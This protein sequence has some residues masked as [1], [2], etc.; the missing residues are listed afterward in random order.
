MKITVWGAR[1]SH[2]HPMT[3]ARFQDRVRSIVQRIGPEDI[4]S[5]EN[6]ERFLSSLPD[7]M[8]HIPGGNTPCV[9]IEL[10]DGSCIVL[11][12]GSGMIP[13]SQSLFSRPVTPELFHIFFSHFH[14]D[15]IQGL[16]F[17]TQ[18]YF[19]N[20]HLHFYSPERDVEFTLKEHMHHPFF[21]VTMEGRMSQ[22]QHFHVLEMS[23]ERES[24]LTIGSATIRWFRLNHPGNSY[25]YRFDEN[26]RS[27]IYATDFEITSLDFQNANGNRNFFQD[28]DVLLLDTMYTLGEAIDKY[29]WGHS[30][31]SIGV[32]FAHSRAAKRLLMFHHEPQYDDRRIYANLRSARQYAQRQNYRDLQIDL[33]QEGMEIILE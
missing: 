9:E 25:A 14:Y 30:S 28:C 16:P 17:F 29:N 12:A 24:S 3:P 21:P 10:A 7:W 4:S 2:P 23:E 19:P 13:F 20:T 1:G 5:N 18:G 26:G 15:H 8:W 6:R 33:A 31:F 11:D 22:N 27:F 32:D